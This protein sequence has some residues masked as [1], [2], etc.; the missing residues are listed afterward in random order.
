MKFLALIGVMAALMSA[1]PPDATV[2][3]PAA[4]DAASGAIARISCGP[5]IGTAFWIGPNRLV[6]AA[7]VT[8]QAQR[9]M[10]ANDAGEVREVEVVREDGALDVAELRSATPGPAF[11][12]IDCGGFRRGQAYRAIGWMG[13][14]LRVN[15]PLLATGFSQN[16]QAEFIGETYPGM[17]GGPVIAA[18]RRG[19][20]AGVINRR[21]PA[22][23]QEL[24][25]TFL[26]RP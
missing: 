17:S 7:H 15:L 4:P 21:W 1:P 25:D 2:S 20:V 19:R 14:Q 23:A 22:A 13:G 24:E 3:A 6:T 18:D 12:S 10:I 11:L 8:S 16:G 5:R 9:C 26:C